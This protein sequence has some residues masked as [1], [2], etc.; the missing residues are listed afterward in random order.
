MQAAKV[1]DS[2]THIP[3]GSLREVVSRISDAADNVEIT[4]AVCRVWP[5]V[6]VALLHGYWGTLAAAAPLPEAMVRWRRD[7]RRRRRRDVRDESAASRVGLQLFNNLD[8][9]SFELVPP[10][11][12]WK[13][14]KPWNVLHDIAHIVRE[15]F[16]EDLDP[17]RLGAAHSTIIA[18]TQQRANLMLSSF[19]KNRTPKKRR[20]Y[21][22]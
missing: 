22:S 1:K 3:V 4:T 7:L 2:Q 18:T 14:E 16:L 5:P 8:D 10:A 9:A 19:G 15:W 6:M 13:D 20:P 11:G 17:Q 12:I 21:T